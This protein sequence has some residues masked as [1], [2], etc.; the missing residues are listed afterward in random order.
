V[1]LLEVPTGLAQSTRGGL[2]NAAALINKK[3]GDPMKYLKRNSKSR[4]FAIAV[5]FSVIM[6]AF[7]VQGNIAST[8]T[9]EGLVSGETVCAAVSST[10]DI[11]LATHLTAETTLATVRTYTATISAGS[12]ACDLGVEVK[13]NDGA[14]N[15][16]FADFCLSGDGRLLLASAFDSADSDLILLAPSVT[17]D[18]RICITPDDQQIVDE[19][20]QQNKIYASGVLVKMGTSPHGMDAFS[21]GMQTIMI[22]SMTASKA[23]ILPK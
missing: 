2:P 23:W 15:P 12:G 6:A 14:V 19:A 17:N 3:E 18:R 9:Q 13:D 5:M 7:A 8:S 21:E 1:A 16:F 4:R 20:K 22:E 11:L 10:G